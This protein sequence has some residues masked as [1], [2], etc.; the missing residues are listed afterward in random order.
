MVIAD[1]LKY[2][3]DTKLKNTIKGM[4]GSLFFDKETS[5]TITFKYNKNFI[6]DMKKFVKQF[7]LVSKTDSSSHFI[8]QIEIS[9][10]KPKLIYFKST[11]KDLTKG[12]AN[13]AG[14]A[15]ANAGELATVLSLT[16]EINSPEDTKQKFFID[17]PQFFEPWKN[18]F[19]QT[20][21]AVN[22]IVGNLK[23]FD[24]IH[25][26]TDTSHWS[27]LITKLVQKGKPYITS[28]DAWNPA[29]LFVINK[30]KRR[31]IESQFEQLL[32]TLDGKD[33]I[34]EVNA[35]VIN[36]YNNKDLYPISLK[37]ITG[38]QAHIEYTNLEKSV[39]PN[40]N[41][42][43]NRIPLDFSL[44]TK[45][46]GVF[47]FKNLE[48]GKLINMQMRPFPHGYSITQCEITSDGSPTGGRLG[49]VPT[50]II[51][52]VFSDFND[53]RIKS[54]NYFGKAKNNKY[55][56]ELDD[57]KVKDIWNQYQN[58]KHFSKTDEKENITSLDQL[59]EIIDFGRGNPDYAANI[60]TKIQ[61]LKFADFFINNKDNIS[62][63]ITRLINGA[64]KIGEFSGFFIK[65]Y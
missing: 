49:K 39:I 17:N 4:G 9:S 43:F 57:S 23:S 22:K 21:K 64:K 52:S 19:I 25:D 12:T 59:S 48:T 47:S 27:D 5:K 1:I 50:N 20:P 35:L 7:N 61:G 63:I 18:T 3:K 10:P 14:K 62:T 42:D 60:V 30:Q 51:D 46:L 55:M 58:V 6:P 37:Q 2:I 56:L 36:E 32:E 16:Q 13:S 34:H 41:I 26:A 65:I 11:G 33:L 40:Y 8:V 45:E 44:E 28:K 29:D 15:L 31:K 53:S 24:I 38:K 54:I